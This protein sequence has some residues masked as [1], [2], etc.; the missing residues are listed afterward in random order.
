MS[1]CWTCFSANHFL[2]VILDFLLLHQSLLLLLLLSV[3]CVDDSHNGD[4]IRHQSVKNSV[5][6][7]NDITSLTNPVSH[8]AAVNF[9]IS[10]IFPSRSPILLW[11]STVSW[12]YINWKMIIPIKVSSPGVRYFVL[13]P[14]FLTWYLSNP[15]RFAC[16]CYLHK[17][18]FN[19][20]WFR[21]W[22]L[23]LITGKSFHFLCY[24]QKV[25]TE[26]PFKGNP[27][28]NEKIP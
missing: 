12:M 18:Y 5:C 4:T 21:C 15:C 19:R 14:V 16:P 13:I 17:L 8:L 9:R 6:T 22:L 23:P 2:L 26:V 7:F 3:E 11:V 24:I 20:R 1:L 28:K 10:F 25:P 27:L